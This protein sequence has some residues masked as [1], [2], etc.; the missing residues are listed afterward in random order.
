VNCQHSP[1]V[2]LRELPKV[3]GTFFAALAVC[4]MVVRLLEYPGRHK[5]L[6]QWIRG[7]IIAKSAGSGEPILHGWMLYCTDHSFETGDFLKEKRFTTIS[8][9]L[10]YHSM[11]LTQLPSRDTV[12]LIFPLCRWQQLLKAPLAPY[13]ANGPRDRRLEVGQSIQLTCR[14]VGNPWPHVR[15]FKDNDQI[16][17][18]GKLYIWITMIWIC[19]EKNIYTVSKATANFIVIHEM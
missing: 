5:A 18:D 6:C 14:V 11:V 4:A 2:F 9:G 8:L 3:C 10:I 17:P 12:H 16:I 13:M 1:F 19:Y 15:W 7:R